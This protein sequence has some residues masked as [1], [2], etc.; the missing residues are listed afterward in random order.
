MW[1]KNKEDLEQITPNQALEYL[2]EGN[3]RFLKNN[4][5]NHDLLKQV[6][7]TSNGQ[8][9]IAAVLSCIDSRTSSEL[10]FDQGIG[11]IFSVRIAGN[12]VNDD[13]LGSLEY[14]CAAANSKLIVV[15]GHTKCGAVISACNNYKSGNIT[16]LLSKISPAIDLEKSIQTDRNGGNLTFVN[17][18]SEINVK[19]SISQIRKKSP[20]LNEMEKEGQIKIVGGMYDIDTGKVSF[21]D[22]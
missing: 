10:I 1:A 17:R 7:Q 2:K 5:I 15:L 3:E 13:I 14:S 22:D 18:V 11:D 20:V 4:M 9:P 8:F 12:I 21:F 16:T 19:A 6:K